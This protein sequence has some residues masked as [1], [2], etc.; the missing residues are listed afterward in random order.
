MVFDVKELI[1]VCKANVQPDDRSNA[2]GLIQERR[3]DN[4]QVGGFMFWKSLFGAPVED[5]ADWK[6]Q[7]EMNQNPEQ[8][9]FYKG[10]VLLQIEATDTT[11]PKKDV[12]RRVDEKIRKAI[13]SNRMREREGYDVLCGFGQG[14]VLPKPETKY[15]VKVRIN[16]TEIVSDFPKPI[17][18]SGTYCRWSTRDKTTSE[19]RLPRVL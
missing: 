18:H 6:K 14:I 2:S 5:V 19:L 15:R 10:A 12:V 1:E 9:T 8:A 3:E 4:S 7:E 17:A 16:A 11:T 13:I